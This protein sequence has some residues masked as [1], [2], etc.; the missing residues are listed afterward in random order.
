MTP[1][2]IISTRGR[3]VNTDDV[4]EE[5]AALLKQ[6]DQRF[7]TGR[8]ALVAVLRTLGRPVTIPQILDAAD[9]LAQSSVYL[10]LIHI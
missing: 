5:V 2:T 7:T 9:G 1:T 4:D 10:S 8:R 3:T 6:A